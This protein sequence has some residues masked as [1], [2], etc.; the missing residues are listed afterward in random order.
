[1]VDTNLIFSDDFQKKEFYEKRR[2]IKDFL[3]DSKP[4]EI[5]DEALCFHDLKLDDEGRGSKWFLSGND[6]HEKL[7]SVTFKKFYKILDTKDDNEVLIKIEGDT[8][9]KTWIQANRF[10]ST[11]S[12]LTYLRKEKLEKLKKLYKKN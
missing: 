6:T 8:G 9:R 10:L 5:G 11:N 1:M 12:V 4:I 7:K 2:I 3:L